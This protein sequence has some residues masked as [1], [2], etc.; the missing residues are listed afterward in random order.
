MYTMLADSSFLVN[1]GGKH[2]Q[3][4][5]FEGSP[6]DQPNED[7]VLPFSELSQLR[8]TRKVAKADRYGFT[9]VST[10]NEQQDPTSCK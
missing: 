3:T 8:S 9:L 6:D 10:S 7:E 1:F 4:A 2:C 5:V